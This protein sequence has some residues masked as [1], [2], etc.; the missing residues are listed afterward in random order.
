MSYDPRPPDSD[1]VAVDENVMRLVETLARQVHDTWAHGRLTDG[2][3]WGPER[4]DVK[5][6]HPCLV[7]YEELSEEERA[8]DRQ[9]ALQTIRVLLALGYRIMPPEDDR[10]GAAD[11]LRK[12]RESASPMATYGR[13]RSDQLPRIEVDAWIESGERLLAEGDYMLAYDLICKGLS[14]V[15]RQGTGAD[16]ALAPAELHDCGLAPGE[17]ADYVRLLQ[18]EGRIL[19]NIR[20]LEKALAAFQS[21]ADAG[22]A[23]PD[24]VEPGVAA[25]TAGNLASVRKSLGLATSD[26]ADRRLHLQAALDL[27]A[28]QYRAHPASYW[29]GINAATLAA[30]V[31]AGDDALKYVGRVLDTCSELAAAAEAPDYWLLATLGEGHLVRH[32]LAGDGNDREAAESFYRRAMD[33]G[34]GVQQLKSSRKNARLLAELA[35][36]ADPDLAGAIDAWLPMP[37]VVLFAGHVPD[38]PGQERPRFPAAAEHGV[39]QAIDAYLEARNARWGYA[40][41]A[42]GADILFHEV[43]QQRGGLSEIVLPYEIEAFQRDCVTIRD[44]ADEGHSWAGRYERILDHVRARNDSGI[45]QTSPEQHEGD[46]IFLHYAN[47]IT[48]G[49]ARM[50]AREMDTRLHGLAVWNASSRHLAGGVA[51]SVRTWIRCGME[52]DCIDPGAAGDVPGVSPLDRTPFEEDGEGAREA[53]GMEM[54]S[55]VFAD[56]GGF[57]RFSEHQIPPYFEHFLGLVESLL[58]GYREQGD[59]V[60]RNTWGDGLYVVFDSL[61]NAGT[62]ALDLCELVNA[63]NASGE[64]GAWG[65]PQPLEVR[66][67]LHTG[68]VFRLYDPVNGRVTYSGRH[69]S[70]AARIEPITPAGEVYASFAAAA[71]AETRNIREFECDYV[72]RIPLAKRYGTLPLFAVR[73][74]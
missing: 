41:A 62:F 19:H 5:R 72:G 6:T 31:G 64:W 14:E 42:C 50:K 74:L 40:S 21:L 33:C 30:L 66:V 28:A 49:L 44:T 12:I 68:P 73:R 47:E 45:W 55:M 39:Q 9:T 58:K 36:D 65:L 1:S 3:T 70:R 26:P 4:D 59:P 56:V 63:R 69:V 57:S 53:A 60:D 35:A 52:V 61:R 11:V 46:R 22:F 43:L 13:R 10:D 16:H 67:A 25:E 27:Y 20:A 38:A 8:Y 37:A 15:A 24:R 23:D 7:P 29:L 18:L 51:R 54:K 34:P 48:C 71:L 17:I 32:V 2:W